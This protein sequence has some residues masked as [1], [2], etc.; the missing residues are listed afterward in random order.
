MT[1][2]LEK[3]EAHKAEIKKLEEAAI[4]ELLQQKEKLQ[5]EIKSWTEEKMNQI[6]KIVESLAEL[7]H[8]ASDIIKGKKTRQTF[9]KLSDAAIKAKLDSVLTV[10]TEYKTDDILKILGISR[11]R[12]ESFKKNNPTFFTIKKAKANID[13]RLLLNK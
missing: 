8:V 10:G 3:I 13:F 12:H 9:P 2:A 6:A 1:T 11:V 4:N 7:G 5:D